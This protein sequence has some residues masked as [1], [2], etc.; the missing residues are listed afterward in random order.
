[1]G[2]NNI[3]AAQNY[4][5]NNE[6]IDLNIF[7]GAHPAQ[8]QARSRSTEKKRPTVKENANVNPN[9]QYTPY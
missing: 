9:Q 3:P 5:E 7:H 8:N 4:I 1:V 6:N 2:R